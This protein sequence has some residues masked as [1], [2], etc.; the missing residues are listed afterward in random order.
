MGEHNDSSKKNKQ[1]NGDQV[2]IKVSSKRMCETV[3][4]QKKALF[5]ILD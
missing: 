3:K 2:E 5:L 1:I 4:W